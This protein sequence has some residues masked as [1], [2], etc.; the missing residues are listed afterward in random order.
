MSLFSAQSLSTL[1]EKT[2]LNKDAPTF[3]SNNIMLHHKC[4]STFV[5]PVCICRKS[6]QLLKKI[7]HGQKN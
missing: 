1:D 5:D 4:G 2:G 3:Y 7:L 6:E